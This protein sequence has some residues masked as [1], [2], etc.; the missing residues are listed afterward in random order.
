MELYDTHWIIK[1]VQAVL[2]NQVCANNPC[3]SS[4]EELDLFDD[5]TAAMGGSL[6]KTACDATT[7]AFPGR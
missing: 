6:D 3:E 5:R 7:I 2:A 1:G 4:S